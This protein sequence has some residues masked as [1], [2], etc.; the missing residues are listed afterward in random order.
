[1]EFMH[2]WGWYC[3]FCFLEFN[4]QQAFITSSSYGRTWICKFSFHI[5]KKLCINL[6]LHSTSMDVE[7]TCLGKTNSTKFKYGGNREW[8]TAML[9]SSTYCHSHWSIYARGVNIHWTCCLS[10]RM[11]KQCHG[12]GPWLEPRLVVNVGHY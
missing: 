2:P 3:L 1:M 6:N 9:F 8:E 5:L 10:S 11:L 12:R 4:I 7:N